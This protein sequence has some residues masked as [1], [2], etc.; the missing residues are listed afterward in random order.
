[1]ADSSGGAKGTFKAEALGLARAEHESE[2][3]K[4]SSDTNPAA[5]RLLPRP[6]S[7][8]RK[9]EPSEWKKN[10]PAGMRVLHQW[11][12]W[13]RKAP[14][15]AVSEVPAR[16]NDPSCFSPWSD[17]AAFYERH[18]K[19]PRRGAGFI[20][21]KGN[22]LVFIDFDHCLDEHGMLKAWAQPL[23]EP[24][25]GETY[26]ERSPSGRGLHVFLLGSLEARPGL[27]GKRV[28]VGDG[29]VEV[30]HDRRHSTV[31]GDVYLES[32][33]L[34]ATQEQLDALLEATGLGRALR[35]RPEPKATRSDTEVDV[36]AVNAAL[37]SIDPDLGHDEWVKIGMALHAGL[38]DDGFKLWEEWSK[39][40]TKWKSGEC[41]KRWASFHRSGITIAS[42]F[43]VAKEHGYK[44][45]HASAEQDFAEYVEAGDDV[46]EVEEYQAGGLAGWRDCNLH[47]VRKGSGK[48]VC[49]EPSEGD[50]NIGQ[51]L[52]NHPKWK[53]RLRYN[54]RTMEV[55]LDGKPIDLHEMG[56]HVLWFMGWKRSPSEDS[57]FRTAK[58]V[59]LRNSYDPVRE[60]LESLTW[61]G[62]QRIDTLNETLRL[63]ASEHARR[64][65]RRWLIGAV[66]RAYTPGVEMQT[67]LVLHGE[68]G[69][70]KSSFFKRM[71][72]RDEWY[73]ES[74]VDMRSK[75][76]QLS[77]LGPWLIEIAELAGMAK[78]EVDKVKVFISER[79]PSFRP[80]YG[81]KNERHPRR[82]VFAGTTNEDEFLRDPT[83]AR[84][85]WLIAVEREL[86]LDYLT[87][88]VVSQLWGEA[89]H[90][91]KHGERWWD[92]S[93][94]V[95]ATIERNAEHYQ[96]TALDTQ[97]ETVLDDLKSQGVTTMSEVVL[98]LHVRF[99]VQMTVRHADIG[100]AM[101]RRGWQHVR[102]KIDG[103]ARRLWKAPSVKDGNLREA[104]VIALKRTV[105]SEFHKV[106]P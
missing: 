70:K 80:P 97:V 16:V 74:Q 81:R 20:F 55:E 7:E 53:D 104:A 8:A 5:F 93:D 77:A 48:N 85:F 95:R 54:E 49:Y 64:Y 66:A 46:D 63:E 96:G 92:E 28:K 42:L 90:A 35:D 89:V 41:S 10:V 6:P 102:L 11:V 26:V 13:H 33:R 52:L 100:H 17:V 86:Q 14:V 72:V 51:Y 27:T 78:A 101:R 106:G 34:G 24:F 60:W 25:I 36:A 73:A 87:S 71:A 61:D 82:A 75:D 65:L 79:N 94:E 103:E 68:Q 83:G 57:V 19:D 1:M 38:G 59:A 98:G 4:D 39:R 76:G 88:E 56:K 12:G 91:F 84:R 3:T 40:G 50:A 67:M 45:P 32:R 37:D 44:R 15:H 23:V 9:L 22:G 47:L 18:Q 29:A 2:A 69:K 99:G 21:T 30:Y 31:T 62:K 58:A 105:G 43:H